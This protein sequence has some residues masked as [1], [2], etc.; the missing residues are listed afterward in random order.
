H[1]VS[2][3]PSTHRPTHLHRVAMRNLLPYCV[4]LL[5]VSGLSAQ[6]T[7]PPDTLRVA[8]DS[9]A[10]RSATD[11]IVVAT[12]RDSAV[13]QPRTQQLRLYGNAHLHHKSQALDAAI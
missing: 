5:A 3:P 7:Q 12:A 1:T 9:L 2:L 10:R 13:F 8:R 11:S 4:L 6:Q